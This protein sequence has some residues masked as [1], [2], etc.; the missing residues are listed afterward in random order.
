MEKRICTQRVPVHLKAPLVQLPV[1][2]S[3]WPSIYFH[4]I[5]ADGGLSVLPLAYH[6]MRSFVNP[7]QYCFY[8]RVETGTHMPINLINTEVYYH[9][10]S[11]FTQIFMMLTFK[12]LEAILALQDTTGSLIMIW[13][14]A[15]KKIY[16]S[17]T[18]CLRIRNQFADLLEQVFQPPTCVKFQAIY[19]KCEALFR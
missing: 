18:E 14:K 1:S 3:I 11:C 16:D 17:R 8:S 7:V 6:M 19:R 4:F 12:N 15:E 10:R 5:D 9:L 13:K 2:N